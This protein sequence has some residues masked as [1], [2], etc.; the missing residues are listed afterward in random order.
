MTSKASTSNTSSRQ[1]NRKSRRT[2]RRN[3]P[4]IL[5]RCVSGSG[6]RDLVEKPLCKLQIK[7]EREFEDPT[8]SID[9]GQGIGIASG[10]EVAKFDAEDLR[11]VTNFQFNGQFITVLPEA[12]ELTFAFPAVDPHGRAQLAQTVDGF[13]NGVGIAN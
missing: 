1:V 7:L 10:G 4:G 3:R 2:I 13:L 5:Q 11:F 6:G 8:L 9:H 12:I